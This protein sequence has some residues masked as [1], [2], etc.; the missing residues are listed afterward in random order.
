MGMLGLVLYNFGRIAFVDIPSMMI[1]GAPIKRHLSREK[2]IPV[3][4]FL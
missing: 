2:S 3:R 4:R 1:A